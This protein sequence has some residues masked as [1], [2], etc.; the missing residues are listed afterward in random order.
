MYALN[1]WSG[2]LGWRQHGGDQL[3]C[4]KV[5]LTAAFSLSSFSSSSSSVI[6]WSWN[7]ILF[8]W[9]WACA[10]RLNQHLHKAWCFLWCGGPSSI[11]RFP[12]APLLG[13]S[14]WTA[15]FSSDDLLWLQW[16]FPSGQPSSQSPPDGVANW[17][18][19]GPFKG[20]LVDYNTEFIHNIL[21]FWDTESIE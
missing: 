15:S 7:Q 17:T 8:F 18:R 11:T 14:L 21:I 9:P 2:L 10:G 1:T 13:Y 20:S 6:P 19:P 3:R 4:R 12:S 16:R 5:V